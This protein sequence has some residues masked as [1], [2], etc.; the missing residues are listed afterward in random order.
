M[1]DYL[2]TLGYVYLALNKHVGKKFKKIEISVHL[3]F[4]VNLHQPCKA[5][6]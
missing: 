4:K 3:T 2:E 5:E 6:E 1:S